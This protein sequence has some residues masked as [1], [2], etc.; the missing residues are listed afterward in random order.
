MT[1][2]YILRHAE[3]EA[4][5]FPNPDLPLPDEPITA[6]GQRQ[7]EALVPFFAGRPIATVYVSAYRRT[8]QT[9][10]PAAR[11]LGL[12]PQVDERL[13]EIDNSGVA[14]LS[15]AQIREKY[16]GIWKAY[17]ERISDFRWPGGET[18]GEARDRVTDF[19]AAARLRHGEADGLAVCHEGLIRLLA[20]ALLGLPVTRRWNFEVNYCGL[21]E[22][23]WQPE[24]NDWRIVRFN[25]DL[26]D[27]G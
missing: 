23:R 18:G 25:Q 24:H 26:T 15:D 13:N 8:L 6:R 16:P 1:T 21:M 9:A 14:R 20:C 11:A 4:G 7:A 2:W 10:A 5:D 19:L 12:T 27:H 3:K 17:T 22:I